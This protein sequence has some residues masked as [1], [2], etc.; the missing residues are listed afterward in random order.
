MSSSNLPLSG[1][2]AL[3]T[4]VSRFNGIGFAVAHRLGR[5]GASLF[6]HGW[7]EYDQRMDYVRQ[8]EVLGY[9]LVDSLRRE[10]LTVDYIESDFMDPEG[11]EQVMHAA[12]KTYGH[13]DIVDAN[14]A[15]SINDRLET[16]DHRELDRHLLVNIRGTLMLVKA[17]A[18]QHDGRP[19]GR[20]FMMTS[21]QHMGTGPGEISY[22]TSKA[23]LHWLTGPLSAVLIERGITVN[24]INPGPV[25][26][27]YATGDRWHGVLDRM[28]L[29]RWGQPDDVA[30]VIGW[31]CTD[32]AQWITGQVTNSEGG[33][34]RR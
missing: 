19:G 12:V 6:L 33:S 31:L 34:R 25:D 26:T 2:V 27:G 10:G 28:P 21:G 16:L 14:H 13:V 20:V 29:G 32:E 1:R 7:P 3:I 4:G 24:T 8:D 9:A 30:N 23:A 15:Y 11:P 17:F 22:M 5:M 18:A